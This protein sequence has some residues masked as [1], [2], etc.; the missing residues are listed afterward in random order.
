MKL[1]SMP[2]LNIGSGARSWLGNPVIILSVLLVL[3]L[4]GMIASFLYAQALGQY[5]TQHNDLITE[6][7]RLAE[8][9][10][11]TATDAASGEA[12]AFDR[13]Q[14][15]TDDF[16][17]NL[18]TLTEGDS[19]SGLP[20]LPE[21]Y[22]S[23]L[24][25]V[26]STWKVEQVNLE[27]IT[28]GRESVEQINEYIDEIRG[29]SDDLLVETSTVVDQLVA[30]DAPPETVQAAS[31]QL[32]LLQRALGSLDQVVAARSGAREEAQRFARDAALYGRVLDGLLQGSERL[33]IEPVEIPEARETLRKLAVNYGPVRRQIDGITEL[34]PELQAATQ[35]AQELQGNLT[36]AIGRLENATSRGGAGTQTITLVAIGFGVAMLV[37]LIILASLLVIGQKRRLE[38][39]AEQNRRNQRAILRLLDELST[40]ADG[41]L[42]THA[43][44]TED[45]TGAIA[46]SVNSAI[47]ALRSLVTTINATA[48][49][50]ARAADRTQST[51]IRLAE[52]SNHQARE[53]AAANEAITE[54]ATSMERVSENA[55]GSAEVAMKSVTIASNGAET[56]RRSISG[57]DSIREQIQET[58]KRIK[59][60]GESSQEIGD[61]IGVIN[62]IAEQTN[63]L[64]L[65]AAIQASTAGEAGRGFA[66][67]ADEVQ[68]LAERATDAT[69]RV[70]ALIK[71]IQN[72]TN[73]AV[74]SMEQ[75]TAGVVSGAKLAEEAGGALGEIESV[76]KQIAE[77]IQQISQEADQQASKATDISE[78]MNIIQGITI[79]TS[80]GTS[81]TATSI[82]EL[83]ALSQEL[84]ESVTGFKLPEEIDPRRGARPGDEGL[85]SPDE[86]LIMEP[87]ESESSGA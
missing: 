69:K 74:Q 7:R 1:P 14:K 24:E 45:I 46:D 8:D 84:R 71:T 57:M 27:A 2:K 68:R 30:G 72:D 34:A 21:E 12:D 82:G 56:V 81:E 35:A 19:E 64:A 41:D 22:E 54:M 80:D 18:R 62:D 61:I 48:E 59:R 66:V 10:S 31:R 33:E 83:T 5:Q 6:Q 28:A 11:T 40:L 29:I 73:E 25:S 49:D 79:Q 47:D 4:A 60:L 50:V 51:A 38:E 75:S 58:S 39:S 36:A 26:E 44:V 67:V 3:F 77:L 42:S 37:T 16:G 9:I 55:R 23:Q 17:R 87:E 52:A 15:L 32:W 86:T 53:I 63:I 76:S 43:T 70:E 78:T 65:N 20:P 85:A 13:L